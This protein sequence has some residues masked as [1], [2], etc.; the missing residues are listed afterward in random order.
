[1]TVKKKLIVTFTYEFDFSEQLAEDEADL[2]GPIIDV[3]EWIENHTEEFD[4]NRYANKHM[5]YQ[6]TP[7]A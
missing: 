6:L 3:Q 4:F 5:T 7:G 2:M 1:M